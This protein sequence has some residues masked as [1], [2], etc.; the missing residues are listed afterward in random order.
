AL[1]DRE[2]EVFVR[3]LSDTALP[4]GDAANSVT[5]FKKNILSLA[6]IRENVTRLGLPASDVVK[7][8]TNVIADVLS[9]VGRL[10]QLT[11]SGEM[12]NAFAAY[13]N[14]LNLKEQAGI[15]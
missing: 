3:S 12:A 13:Y 4:E 2:I 14:L 1:T 11:D 15:E 7:F 6:T 8:Y 10:G 9:F 5:T